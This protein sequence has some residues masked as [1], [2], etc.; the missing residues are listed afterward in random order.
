[1]KNMKKIVSMLLLL[2]MLFSMFAL[3]SCNL[4]VLK[5]VKNFIDFEYFIEWLISIITGEELRYT[6]TA[7]EWTTNKYITNYTISIGGLLATL[8][9]T[10]Y[11]FYEGEDYFYFVKDG[12]EYELA[13]VDG[14][15]Y[16]APNKWDKEVGIS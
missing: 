12:V 4:G 6:I 13:K 3:T 10:E 2:T 7:E 1:M 15:W 11:A 8:K 9:S 16:A 14:K 5:D